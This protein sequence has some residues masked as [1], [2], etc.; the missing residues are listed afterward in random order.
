GASCHCSAF[1]SY[2]ARRASWTSRK[3]PEAEAEAEAEE[4]V[5]A[6]GLPAESEYLTGKWTAATRGAS[7]AV[8]GLHALPPRCSRR[9]PCSGS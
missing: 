8:R 6:E 3:E 2:S 4:D 5:A 9:R 7:A 1:S